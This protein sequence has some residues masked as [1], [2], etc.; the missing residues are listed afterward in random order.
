MNREERA[1]RYEHW[2]GLLEEQEKSGLSCK[3]FCEQHQLVLSQFNYYRGIIKPKDPMVIAN[4]NHFA[5]VHLNKRENLSREIQIVL[6]NGFQCFVPKEM[7]ALAIKRLLGV[8]LS[9]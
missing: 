1:Q 2:K 7:D 3:L 6:P 9:C 5:P 8:L 4:K